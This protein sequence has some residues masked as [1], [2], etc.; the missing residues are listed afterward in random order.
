MGKILNKNKCKYDVVNKNIIMN[1]HNIELSN[2]LEECN[3]ANALFKYNLLK[4][5]FIKNE[6]GFCKKLHKQK[7]PVI[8]TCL[9]N[10]L[11]DEFPN[12]LK[13]DEYGL[14]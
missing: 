2:Y 12:L 10:K 11:I 13:K 8:E 1:K 4:C 5:K 6:T 14:N 3:R 9:S 7:F